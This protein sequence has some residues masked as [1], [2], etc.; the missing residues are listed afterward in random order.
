MKRLKYR[1]WFW[2]EYYLGN[3]FE[4]RRF[5]GKKKTK[6]ILGFLFHSGS[7]VKG[8]D[9]SPSLLLFSDNYKILHQ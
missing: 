1:T 7:N 3:S 6:H 8:E 4:D 5:G 9:T 2:E